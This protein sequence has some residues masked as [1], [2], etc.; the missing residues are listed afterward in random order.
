[1][2]TYDKIIK[3]DGYSYSKCDLKEKEY[4]DTLSEMAINTKNQAYTIRTY[5]F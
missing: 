5:N 4:S 1:M 3:I 2:I